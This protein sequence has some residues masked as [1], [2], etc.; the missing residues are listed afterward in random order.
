VHIA[1][2][3]LVNL[4]AADSFAA[5]RSILPCSGAYPELVILP[6]S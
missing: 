1:D 2:Y 6:L 5:R 4:R 3:A